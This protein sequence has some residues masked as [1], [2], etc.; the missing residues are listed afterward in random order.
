M[1]DNTNSGECKSNDWQ[2]TNCDHR[3]TTKAVHIQQLAEDLNSLEYNALDIGNYLR[4]VFNDG[5]R[6]R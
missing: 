4:Q 2:N 5:N 1:T 6:F 3:Y